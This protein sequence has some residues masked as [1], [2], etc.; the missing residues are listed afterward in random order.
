MFQFYIHFF[1]TIQQSFTW[2]FDFIVAATIDIV[3]VA[4]EDNVLVDVVREEGICNELSI[5]SGVTTL[6]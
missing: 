1:K 6:L 2:F 3:L 4:F 5:L